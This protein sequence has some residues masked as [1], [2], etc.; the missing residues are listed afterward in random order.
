[1]SKPLHKFIKSIFPTKDTWSMAKGEED[2]AVLLF[3]IRNNIPP[4]ILP[5]QFP[6]LINIYWHYDDTSNGGLPT[7]EIYTRMQDLEG[8]LDSIEAEG[9]DF[10]VL[11]ITGNQ[12]KEWMLYTHDVRQFLNRLNMKLQALPAFPIEIETNIDPSWDYYFRL[13]KQL[14]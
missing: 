10:F 13:I 14:K 12:R 8:H 1:M 2:G 6:N 4:K 9:D 7:K 3:R 5:E 11:S